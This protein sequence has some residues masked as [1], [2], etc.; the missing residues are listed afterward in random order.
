MD[1][2]RILGFVALTVMGPL[3]HVSVASAWP[4]EGDEVHPGLIY[5]RLEGPVKVQGSGALHQV[6][7]ILY[8]DAWNSALSF[9]APRPDDRN[10][11]IS[12]F[13][14]R[15]QVQA[16]INANYFDID[17]RSCGLA[18]GEGE[19]WPDSYNHLPWGRCSDSVG[20][21]EFNDVVFF[22]SYEQLTGPLPPGV[23]TV[24][25]GM[26]TLVRHGEITDASAFSSTDYPP[27]LTKRNPRTAL[28]THSDDRTVVMV[29]VEG[30]APLQG[31]AGM[32]GI[33]LARFM[34]DV[35][36][37]QNAVAL[38]GGGSSVMFVRGQQAHGEQLPGLVS[39][40]PRGDE[41]RL[42][43]HLG[44]RIVDG[45]SLWA[46]EIVDQ[47]PV[48][49]V[50]AG[51]TFDLWVRY[52]NSGRRTWQ[53][54]GPWPVALVTDD[55][56]EHL[57]LLYAEEEWITP[58]SPILVEETTLPGELGTFLFRAVAPSEPGIYPLVVSPVAHG[59]GRLNAPSVR[60]ELVVDEA[61]CP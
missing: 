25:T 23:D 39:R 21:S 5:R 7:H 37:C 31:R 6:V 45:S 11:T 44:I 34:R 58:M 1:Q 20:F 60:W 42:G 53:R 8:V 17:R 15:Y 16:A 12:Q 43:N 59:A 3:L 52:R 9:V 38:D 4:H 27:N 26:P 41:R 13:A 56:E 22:D 2:V 57:S 19:V 51:E 50:V 54:E 47:S 49:S 30:R 61:E 32:T 18:A 29:V 28:C 36:G 55:P 46:A 35:L 14:D 24:V 40:I 48:P 33:V 10:L